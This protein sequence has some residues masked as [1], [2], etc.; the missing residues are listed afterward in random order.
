MAKDK[1]T[2]KEYCKENWQDLALYACGIAAGTGLGMILKERE[3]CGSWKDTK[4][5]VRHVKRFFTGPDGKYTIHSGVAVTAKSVAEYLKEQDISE[6]DK[7]NFML[8]VPKK[9]Q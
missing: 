5:A 3:V 4:E 8:L 6:D 9:D 2:F 1:G 7:V